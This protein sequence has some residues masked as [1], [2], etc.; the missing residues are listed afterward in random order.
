ML[1]EIPKL[2]LEKTST[3]GNQ[4]GIYTHLLRLDSDIPIQ[5]S[6]HCQGEPDHDAILSNAAKESQD[7]DACM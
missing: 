6:F 4:A 7:D 3:K 2:L 5:S 1:V